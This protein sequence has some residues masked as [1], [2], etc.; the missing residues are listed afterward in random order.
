M[1]DREP[2]VLRDP[3][4]PPPAERPP[5]AASRLADSP[6]P[7]VA[8][9]A[10]YSGIEPTQTVYVSGFWR[11]L[12]A[13]IVDA[14]IALP[15]A[16]GLAA[17]AGRLAG[18][19]LPSARHAGVDYWLDL[20]LAGD[21]A[22]WGAIGLVAAIAVLY[23]FLFQAATGRTPGMR[24]LGLRVIDVYGRSPGL[25]RVSLRV[26]G[27]LLGI[28]TLG[29]GFIWMGFDREKRGLQDWLGGTYVVKADPHRREI[30]AARA[31]APPVAEGGAGSA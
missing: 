21:P 8:R 5:A 3:T 16:L 30:P 6:A 15:V 13:A 31:T 18:L 1:E 17:V 27:Y 25:L 11:R 22:L 9:R 12:V 20:W 23:L 26:V 7:A 28:A 10:T 4:S 2:S 19:S 24:V 14:A 29:L